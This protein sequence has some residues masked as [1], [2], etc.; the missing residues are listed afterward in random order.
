MGDVDRGGLG[1]YFPEGPRPLSSHQL[2]PLEDPEPWDFEVLTLGVGEG[3]DQKVSE[4]AVRASPLTW[5]RAAVGGGVGVLQQWV[6]PLWLPCHLSTPG[7]QRKG[8]REVHT[9]GQGARARPQ[10]ALRL[11]RG[12]CSR[13]RPAERAPEGGRSLV[14]TETPHLQNSCS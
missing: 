1:G 12:T 11:T 8:N 3:G 7:T 5:A 2:S 13:A 9:K 4:C 10:M 14:A 6:S